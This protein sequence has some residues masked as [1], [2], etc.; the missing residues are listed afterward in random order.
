MI[1]AVTV[2]FLGIAGMDTR[3]AGWIIFA[4][5]NARLDRRYGSLREA[6]NP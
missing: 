5:G 6:L 3:M 4:A 1:T 2:G